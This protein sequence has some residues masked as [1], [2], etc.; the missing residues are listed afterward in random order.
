MGRFPPPPALPGTPRRHVLAAGTLL[1]RV[2]SARRAATAFNPVP[3]HCLYGGGRFDGTRCDPYGYL[4]AGLTVEAAI[5]ETLLRSV[6]FEAS[7]RPRLLPRR[8]VRGRRVSV[9]RL[10]REVRVVPLVSGR[11]LAAVGQDSWLVQA[12]AAEY[13]FTRDW[14]HWI[15]AGA[16]PDAQGFLWPSKREPADRALVLFGDRCA[17]GTLVNADVPPVDLDTPR[18]TGW[19]N[20]VL[21]GYLAAV[22]PESGAA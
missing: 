17:D 7:D 2:H 8:T 11:D 14:G 6:P 4:Y 5:C 20:A 9:L 10:A 1:Y 13:P 21:E 12:E 22:P 15:R 3:A 18:G 19:L 16:G